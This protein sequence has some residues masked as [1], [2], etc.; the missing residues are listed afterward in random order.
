MP[1]FF[2]I[3]EAEQLLPEVQRILRGLMGYKS[4]YDEAADGLSMIAQ[5]ITIMGGIIPSHDSVLLLRNRRY[6]AARAT[7]AA[8]DQLR[9]TGCHL[10]DL[11][12]GRVDFPTLYRGQEV[13]LCWKLGEPGIAFWHHE[14][15]GNP[16]RLAIDSE[17]L[18]NHR[19]EE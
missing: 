4:E 7:R 5:R 1:R 18:K 15:D 12:S 16:D 2:N 19:G 9:H 17:F 14:N 10:K 6:A 11:E 13:Y 3:E 8:V